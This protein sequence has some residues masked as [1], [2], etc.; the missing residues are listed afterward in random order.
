MHSGRRPQ[1]SFSLSR[2]FSQNMTAVRL[3][4]FKVTVAGASKTLGG[5]TVSFYFWHL[6]APIIKK[7]KSMRKN[8]Q[9]K[10]HGPEKLIAS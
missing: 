7:I 8:Q 6:F 4:A 9:G 5:T 3:P 10:M 2:F 1:L